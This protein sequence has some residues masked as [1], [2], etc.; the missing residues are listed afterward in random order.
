MQTLKLQKKW[1]QFYLVSAVTIFVSIVGAY[2]IFISIH[3]PV[4]NGQ[5]FING[6]SY[7]SLSSIYLMFFVTPF[8]VMWGMYVDIN[9][10]ICEKGM[11]NFGVFK[12]KNVEWKDVSKF[13]ADSFGITLYGNEKRAR[14]NLMLFSNKEEIITF[15]KSQK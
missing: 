12:N 14:I 2:L 4:I 8:I 6:W 13:R 11:S 5:K 7:Y 9:I 10:K 3:Y 1:L 15:I